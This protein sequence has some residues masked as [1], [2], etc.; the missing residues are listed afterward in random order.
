MAEEEWLRLNDTWL[1]L[2]ALRGR[3]SERK[4]R[5]FA[6][7]CASR[8]NRTLTL[9]GVQDLIDGIELYLEREGSFE[10]VRQHRQ[11]I[12]RLCGRSRYG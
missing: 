4:G 10:D 8:I 11:S 7:A 5:L 3:V 1:M 6:L 9:P 12:S 2:P